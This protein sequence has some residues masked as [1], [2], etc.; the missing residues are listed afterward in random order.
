MASKRDFDDTFYYTNR[1]AWLTG[2]QPLASFEEDEA[3]EGDYRAQRY[4]NWVSPWPL[5]L[6]H[7]NEVHAVPPHDERERR[8]DCGDYRE[9]GHDVVLLNVEV[10]L[11]E[12]AHLK[13]LISKRFC[14]VAH[15]IEPAVRYA[16]IAYIAFREE[17]VLV[18]F[19]H[20]H[21]VHQVI[22]VVVE[23]AQLASH[24]IDAL[25]EIARFVSHD[26]V[27]HLVELALIAAQQAGVT[28]HD[29]RDEIGEEPRKAR[30]LPALGGGDVFHDAL[31]SVV[32]IDEDD[33]LLVESEREAC[34]RGVEVG[35]V[36]NEKGSGHRV[37]VGFC[38]SIEHGVYVGLEVDSHIERTLAT[39]PF[40][41]REYRD[42]LRFAR[43][44]LLARAFFH[45]LIDEIVHGGSPPS[46][47]SGSIIYASDSS[48]SWDTILPRLERYVQKRNPQGGCFMNLD[49]KLAA[50]PARDDLLILVDGFDREIG[51]VTKIQA[52]MD[53]SLHRAFSVVLVREGA[54][55]HELLLA[56][57]SMPKYHSGG[58]W[59]NSCCSHPRVG[60]AV[61]DAAYRRVPEELGCEALDLREL[62][63]FVYRAE[64]DNGLV[65]HEYDHV[66]VGS[67][68]GEI[69]P[70][71][72]EA[73][74]ARWVG[75]DE[76][77]AELAGEPK[78]FAAWV[79]IVLTLVMND[80]AR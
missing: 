8:K 7:M 60:E 72:A 18:F 31:G 59:A 51:S 80:L 35:A 53:G 28:F 77:A 47:L 14:L 48:E 15:F 74:E 17:S 75:F 65:E 49:E 12:V 21:K 3:S 22:I 30:V 29:L 55:G 6:G 34:L 36:W 76:L 26:G 9:H 39:R 61:I 42:E 66:L 37:I 46:V 71:P 16:E 41:G 19:K 40:L 56:K 79:P 78:K 45:S 10:H 52:H 1:T 57:R 25:G 73:S 23:V 70:N 38:L 64:V 2:L 43:E 20:T 62:C 4:D 58:L 13:R 33:P 32:G 67:C 44:R 54:H 5:E 27:F 68:K 24:L 63:A 69:A 50:D 11:V